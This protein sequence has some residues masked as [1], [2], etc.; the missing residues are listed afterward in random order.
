MFFDLPPAPND[1]LAISV[2]IEG[3][4]IRAPYLF[5]IPPLKAEWIA[6]SA[7]PGIAPVQTA[8]WCMPRKLKEGKETSMMLVIVDGFVAAAKAEWMIASG[9]AWHVTA[10]TVAQPQVNGE[11]PRRSCRAIDQSVRRLIRAP[12]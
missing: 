4:A 8:L 2:G 9:M 5:R 6:S 3:K 12:Q 7:I 10:R 11:Q 1:Y